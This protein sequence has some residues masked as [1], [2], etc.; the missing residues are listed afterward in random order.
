MPWIRTE[1]VALN[2]TGPTLN[3]GGKYRRWHRTVVYECDE[4]KRVMRRE[5]R[6]NP[7]RTNVTDATFCTKKCA[8]ATR[9][10]NRYPSLGEVRARAGKTCP[11]CSTWKP[12]AEFSASNDKRDGLSTQCTPCKNIRANRASRRR[13][14]VARAAGICTDCETAR[15]PVGMQTCFQCAEER[16]DYHQRLRAGRIQRGV[17]VGCNKDAAFAAHMCRT[18]WF[19]R[20]ATNTLG[21]INAGPMIEA[22]WVAQGGRCAL[23]GVRLNPGN[24]QTSLD[25]I[26]PRAAGGTNET[27]NLR[28][29]TYTANRA[30][31]D[32]SDA[33]FLDMCRRV[34]ATLGGRAS[35]RKTECPTTLTLYGPEKAAN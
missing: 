1:I 7:A 30:K 29:V 4:C 11:D 23:T 31:S 2:L 19:R 18:C 10:R 28:W 3:A 22:I 17:C 13:Y 24:R 21:D 33:E 32:M 27:S 5:L 26:T 20:V 9:A 25:H 35:V 8:A 14:A 16:G 15:A 6:K 12:N 34:V